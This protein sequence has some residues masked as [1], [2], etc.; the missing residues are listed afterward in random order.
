MI[1]AL[2]PILEIS[3]IIPGMLLAYL[4]TSNYLKQRHIQVLSWMLPMLIGLSVCGGLLS[5]GLNISS[6]PAMLAAILIAGFA[7]VKSLRVS[8]WKS[9]NVALAIC[10][11]FACVNSLSRAINAI[12]T[13]DLN[14]AENELWFCLGAGLVYNLICWVFVL[15]AWYPAT[16]VVKT[17]VE[18]ENIAQTWYV[19]WIL[20]LIFIGLNLFM[21]PRHR[22]T[23]YQGVLY[24][25]ILYS[26]L[27][28]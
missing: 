17:L 1:N 4:P 5:Y 7:Y 21:V 11:V 9:G 3:V 27:C 20:T 8:A 22:E 26:A 18:D 2:R 23:L 13:A 28:C 16:H 15:F 14:I 6:A 10:A 12:M 19:F 25:A 24:R